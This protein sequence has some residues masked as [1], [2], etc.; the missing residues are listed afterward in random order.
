MSK[1]RIE[2]K[3]MKCYNSLGKYQIQSNKIEQIYY[4]R[5]SALNVILSNCTNSRT[6]SQYMGIV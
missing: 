1:M 4:Q 5:K 3:T 2:T 6:C